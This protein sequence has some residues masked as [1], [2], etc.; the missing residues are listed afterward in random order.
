VASLPFAPEIVLPT[1]KNFENMELG[2]LEP[3]GFKA[4]FN[5]TFS[6]EGSDHG[7]V[8]PWTSASTRGRSF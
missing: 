1:I 3:F 5:Q 7:W 8:S 6:V 4:T 2:M